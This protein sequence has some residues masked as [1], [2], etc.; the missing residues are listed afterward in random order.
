MRDLLGSSFSH[1]RTHSTTTNSTEVGSSESTTANP[2]STNNPPPPPPIP[3]TTIHPLMRAQQRL[4]NTTICADVEAT[5]KDNDYV[6]DPLRKKDPN[7]TRILF[8]NVRGLSRD[9]KMDRMKD[10]MK[11]IS[12]MSADIVGF[13]EINIDDSKPKVS[14]EIHDSLRANFEHYGCVSSTSSIPSEN[15]F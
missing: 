3:P 13:A 11:D 6:G 9:N 15:I 12:M 7:H 10:L 1:R 8:G 2:I 14:H 4:Q 5:P